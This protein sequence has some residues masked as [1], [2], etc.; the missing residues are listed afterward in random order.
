MEQ[1]H[2]RERATA[3]AG[4][5]TAQWRIFSRVDRIFGLK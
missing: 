5:A 3:R 2:R 1:M 4:L